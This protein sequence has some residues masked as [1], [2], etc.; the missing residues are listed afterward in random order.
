MELLARLGALAQI[1]EGARE[2]ALRLLGSTEGQG[3]V[4][5]ATDEAQRVDAPIG[6][7]RGDGARRDDA[8]SDFVELGQRLD[9][10]LEVLHRARAVVRDRRRGRLVRAIV[11]AVE[12]H[13]LTADLD[14]V[15]VSR[16]G[17][18]YV[19]LHAVD[20]DA[21]A[22]PEILEGHR[23]V[24]TDEQRV[25]ARD[26]RIVER[27]LAIRRPADDELPEGNLEIM[28]EIAQ[29]DRHVAS[30][31]WKRTSPGDAARGAR[32]NGSGRADSRIRARSA[33]GP[34]E[35]RGGRRSAAPSTSCARLRFGRRKRSSP[36]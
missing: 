6:V 24:W 18:A 31:Y 7:R 10:R 13:L 28:R 1:D 30:C 21:V 27:E 17:F 32:S 25:A 20:E 2:D 33:N 12:G 29:P 4:R 5:E 9:E 26:E 19:D 23:A 36:R 3:L 8:L 11:D 35:A 15:A 22:A 16:D 34:A 14:D